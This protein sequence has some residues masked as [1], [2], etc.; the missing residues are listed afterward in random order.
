MSA[1]EKAKVGRK[2]VDV[3]ERRREILDTTVRLFA[4]QGYTNTNLQH[5]ADEMGYGKGTVYLY[6]KSKEE[7]FLASVEHAVEK[8]AERIDEEVNHSLD[9]V[10]KV[11][12]IVRA[13]L[14]FI[15]QQGEFADL[16]VREG[17][18]FRSHAES[19][20]YQMYRRNAEKTALIIQDG[21]DQGIFRPVDPQKAADMIANLLTGTMHSYF[22]EGVKGCIHKEIETITDFL[23]HGLCNSSNEQK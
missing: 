5:V 14:L 10:D 18:K 4:R 22:Q 7:L 6:F 15:D 2:P 17:A 9:P 11:K 16:I 3:D 20:F 12:A 21:I 19:K 8:L 13:F 23:L 1:K